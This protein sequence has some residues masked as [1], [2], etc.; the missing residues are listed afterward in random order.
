[1]TERRVGMIEYSIG[2]LSFNSCTHTVDTLD[3]H[4]LIFKQVGL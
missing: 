2:K 4:E 1:M 3:L